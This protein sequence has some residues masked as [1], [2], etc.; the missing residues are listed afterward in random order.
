MGKQLNLLNCKFGYLT[1]IQKDANIG[2]KTAWLCL[3]SCGKEKSI[4]TASLIN[5]DTQS[6]GDCNSRLYRNGRHDFTILNG[7][8]FGKLLVLNQDIDKSNL[9][10]KNYCVCLCD[11]GNTNTIAA[12]S[13]LSGN[14]M[15]CGCKR[16]K[17][18][19]GHRSFKDLKS[20]V[21]GKLTVLKYNESLSI[22]KNISMWTCA[23]TCGEVCDVMNNS[24]LSGKTKSCGCNRH[25]PRGRVNQSFL[26]KGFQ[27]ISGKFFSQIKRGA[28]KREFPFVL[29]IQYIWNLFLGQNRKCIFTGDYLTFD[30][31][32][33]A[34]DG[35]AS[36]DRIDSSK[37][38]GYVEGN[39][40]WVHKKLQPMKMAMKDKEF[41][42]WC[43]KISK[44]QEM[45]S[46]DNQDYII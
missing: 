13:L 16:K 36:L 38:K 35:V 9:T 45:K 11:C 33:N 27:E 40:Q 26:F 21:F 30:T 37:D 18:G 44:H 14:T 42:D 6:C 17:R 8:K 23:C 29:S 43:H 32:A 39:V 4:R 2:V 1:V 20:L 19:Y 3:C 24:L 46:N 41:I 15:S 31:H 10:G 25:M 7:R 22:E 28:V 5:G 12:D 34:G